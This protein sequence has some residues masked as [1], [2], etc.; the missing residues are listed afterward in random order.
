MTIENWLGQSNT[1][2]I[3]IWKK[4]YRHNEEETF[5]QWID[6]ISGGDPEVKELILDKKFL[7][8]GRILYGRGVKGLK[9][10]Y[11]NCYVIPAPE[12]NI[13][14]IFECA[15]RLARTYSYGGGCGTDLSKLR[16]DGAEVHNASKSS[17]GPV[18]FM[19]LFSQVTETISQAGRRK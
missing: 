16:P 6:R 4:K 15:K 8:G 5:D 17:S 1:L 3:D 14:S 11:S 9:S 18:S 13:E 2:G 12:D 10:T 19:D 7:F